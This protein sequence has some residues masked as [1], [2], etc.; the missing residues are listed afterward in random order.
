MVR[1]RV[2]AEIMTLMSSDMHPFNDHI[3]YIDI[4]N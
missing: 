3:I 1:E 4:K 2:N